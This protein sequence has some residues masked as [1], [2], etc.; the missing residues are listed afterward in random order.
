[1]YL[2]SLTVVDSACVM[3]LQ[4]HTIAE[5][6][7]PEK[8]HV[9][10]NVTSFWDFFRYFPRRIF[11][12]QVVINSTREHSLFYNVSLQGL[13]IPL[14]AFHVHLDCLHC[15]SNVTGISVSPCLYVDFSRVDLIK[16]GPDLQNILR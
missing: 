3:V 1:M 10:H 15:S 2:P 12:S 9:I 16:L 8:R 6:Y 7:E 11:S 14:Q 4:V 13:E 5:M